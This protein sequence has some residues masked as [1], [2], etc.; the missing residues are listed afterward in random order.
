MSCSP[1]TSLPH[2]ATLFPCTISQFVTLP[3]TC[4]P[5]R[6]RE[7]A[8]SL[9][10]ASLL[11]FPHSITKSHP[12]SFCNACLIHYRNSLSALPPSFTSS[13]E[14]FSSLCTGLSTSS[15]FIHLLSRM[16]TN[17]SQSGDSRAPAR[18]FEFEC[19]SQSL[20]KLVKK[21]LAGS[22]PRVPDSAGRDGAPEFRFQTSPG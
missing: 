15:A 4:H 3:A 17:G 11:C 16:D 18:A 21:Q 9:P 14:L 1:R 22:H 19:A 5:N 6:E 8:W 2:K 12:F 10:S 13:F 7:S 20:K